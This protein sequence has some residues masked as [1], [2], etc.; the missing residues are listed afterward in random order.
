[1]L[2]SAASLVVARA[3]APILAAGLALLAAPPARA[4]DPAARPASP[5]PAAKPAA[6]ENERVVK[7]LRFQLPKGFAVE[8]RFEKEPGETLELMFVAV[9]GPVEVHA[10]VE[11]GVIDCK[12]EFVG[13]TARSG[14]PMAGHE[15]CE[16]EGVG[17]PSMGA[18]AGPRSAAKVEV[19]FP[20][21]H[22]SVVVFAPGAAQ[23]LELARQV[24]QSC[25]EMK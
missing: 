12:S 11:D 1:M 10:E 7:G 2:R 19:Q 14:R 25:G 3:L 22:L 23:A 4:G 5:A 18:V 16:N 15:T 21:R 24:A 8:E 6:P 9:R 13:G 20:G 17:P